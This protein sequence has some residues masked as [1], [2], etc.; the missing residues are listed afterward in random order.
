M[1]VFFL[2]GGSHSGFTPPWVRLENWGAESREGAGTK[3]PRASILPGTASQGCGAA[4][5]GRRVRDPFDAC[6][7]PARPCR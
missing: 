5:F 4:G 1:R 6:S 2:V 3:L 7:S